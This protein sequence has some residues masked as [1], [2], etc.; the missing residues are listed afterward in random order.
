MIEGFSKQT[1]NLTD[2]E[3]NTLLPIM[4]KC[5]EKH[6]GKENAVTNATICEKMNAKGYE[7]VSEA[8]VR[9]IINYIRT[10]NLVP[11]LMASGS[12]YYITNNP[13][14]LK[15]YIESLIGRKEAIEGV[16]QAVQ[17]QY[18]TLVA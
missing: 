9:K 17:K 6:I 13:D 11:R 4:C 16:I 10:K 2:Y 12:G 1:H 7:K 3:K 5:F 8:R 15:D 14:E 18:D